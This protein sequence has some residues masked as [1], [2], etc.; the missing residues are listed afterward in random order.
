MEK[1]KMIV[2]VYSVFGEGIKLIDTEGNIYNWF[3]K[4][5]TSPLYSAD[6]DERFEISAMKYTYDHPTPKKG[7]K[8]VRVLKRI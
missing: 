2:R 8:Y 4:S 7:L 1:V 5:Y 3:T 6:N